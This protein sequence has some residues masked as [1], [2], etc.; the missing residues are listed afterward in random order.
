M[1]DD[2][3]RRMTPAEKVAAVRDA[4][5]S[6]RALALA[7]LRLDHPH[8]SDEELEERW[9]ERRLGRELYR[10]VVAKRASVSR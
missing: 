5:Q 8:E 7:G 4:W 10:R 3:H 1:L 2:H 6:A 9:A